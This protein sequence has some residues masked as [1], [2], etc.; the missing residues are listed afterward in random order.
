MERRC[1]GIDFMAWLLP[2]FELTC[3]FL[4]RGV[5]VRKEASWQWHSGRLR[6]NARRVVSLT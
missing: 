5:E 3:P 1:E 4:S 6:R 2:D